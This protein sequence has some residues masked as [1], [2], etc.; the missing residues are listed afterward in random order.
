[1]GIH[2]HQW[3]GDDSHIGKASYFLAI[4]GPAHK[5]G[6]TKVELEHPPWRGP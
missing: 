6:S 1:M 2:D 3:F 5:Y 4:N